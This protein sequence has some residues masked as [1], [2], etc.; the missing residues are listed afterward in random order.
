ML[1]YLLYVAE[2]PG[3]TNFP[4]EHVPPVELPPRLGEELDHAQNFSE[5]MH[6][7]ALLYN[8]LLAREKE[9]ND[10][11]KEYEEWLAEWWEE[12]KQRSEELGRWSRS[13]LWALLAAWRARVTPPTY[14]FVETWLSAIGKVRRIEAILSDPGLLNLIR[15]R[16]RSLKRARARLGNPRALDLWNGRSGAGQLDYRWSRPVRKML[17]DLLRPT[18]KVKMNA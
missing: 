7:A 16:E 12:L 4:W 3:K 9:S 5:T 8:L 15:E 18:S 11:I 1:A 2:P 13:R 6:G 14:S 10:L 17:D